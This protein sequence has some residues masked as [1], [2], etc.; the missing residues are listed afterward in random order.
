ML[1][2]VISLGLM[3]DMR[4]ELALPNLNKSSSVKFFS[5]HKTA[6]Y[7]VKAV[8]ILGVSS[9]LLEPSINFRLVLAIS[10]WEQAGAREP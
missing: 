9:E 10:I 7:V 4:E 3:F 6:S 2:V 8:I 5:V 1:I